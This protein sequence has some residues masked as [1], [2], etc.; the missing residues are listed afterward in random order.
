MSSAKFL[1]KKYISHIENSNEFAAECNDANCANWIQ[2]VDCF[3][4]VELSSVKI[5]QIK[6]RRGD[7]SFLHLIAGS[8]PYLA[9]A[10]WQ[11][12]FVSGKLIVF[13]RRDV[14]HIAQARECTQIC[15]RVNTKTVRVCRYASVAYILRLFFISPL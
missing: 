9:A 5:A 3:F 2:V 12:G 6:N 15:V 10:N 7:R 11:W 4:H 1:C 13:Y 14:E 8:F